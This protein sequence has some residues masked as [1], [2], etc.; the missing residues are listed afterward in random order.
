MFSVFL[1]FSFWGE[2]MSHPIETNKHGDAEPP[3]TK[4]GQLEGARNLIR[5]ECSCGAVWIRYGN[6][7]LDKRERQQF[8]AK[9]AEHN[10]KSI[11]VTSK[12]YRT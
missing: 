2:N 7:A 11:Q 6:K 4:V 1:L 8:I 10:L 9:H 12:V 3:I 5:I